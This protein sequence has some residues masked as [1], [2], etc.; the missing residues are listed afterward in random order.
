MIDE[1]PFEERVDLLATP[2]LIK[3]MVKLHESQDGLIRTRSGDMTKDDVIKVIGEEVAEHLNDARID[4]LRT[5]I[6]ISNEARPG[7]IRAAV[8]DARDGKLPNIPIKKALPDP[9][10]LPER[11][12]AQPPL[13]RQRGNIVYAY[14]DANNVTQ[15]YTGYVV[16]L[17]QS[18]KKKKREK[19]KKNKKKKKKKS[20]SLLGN[21][22]LSFTATASR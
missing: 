1:E 15:E 6:E 20:I 17:G 18:A 4:N 3:D 12:Q 10:D 14:D 2:S 7:A 5:P 22:R 19:K 21:L 13:F 8:L 9:D 16:H 11:R